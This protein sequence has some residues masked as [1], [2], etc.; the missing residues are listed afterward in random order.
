MHAARSFHRLLLPWKPLPSS[1]SLSRLLP[2]ILAPAALMASQ[3]ASEAQL[4]PFRVAVKEQVNVR[5]HVARGRP[6]IT[7][8]SSLSLCLSLSLSLSLPLPLPLP[9]CLPPSLS[10]IQGDLVRTIK[11]EGRPNLEV[12]AA[13]A[14]L[15]KRKSALEKKEK[16]LIPVEGKID[17]AK[18][19]DTLKRRFFYAPLLL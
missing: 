19:E 10:P 1:L 18:L 6:A 14:E 7:T 2:R 4:A 13:V 16:E 12:Q 11:A 5:G 8:T 17:R 3:S 9:P 15:K